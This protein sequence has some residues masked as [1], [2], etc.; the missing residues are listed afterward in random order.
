MTAL[1]RARARG[2]TGAGRAMQEASR[3]ILRARRADGRT[4]HPFYWA[5]FTATGD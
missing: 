4:T 5:A 2:A 1:H 3:E